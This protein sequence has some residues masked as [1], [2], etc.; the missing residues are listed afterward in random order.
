MQRTVEPAVAVRSGVGA[1]GQRAGRAVGAGVAVV[2]LLL[3][4]GGRGHGPAMALG[5]RGKGIC[6]GAP[7]GPR[8]VVARRAGR[9]HG[10]QV[11]GQILGRGVLVDA[12]R[13][14][15]MLGVL[16]LEVAPGV[17]LILG[18]SEE[19]MYALG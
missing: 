13:L 8:P 16:L 4:V 6:A 7:G 14:H 5:P 1:G 17:S 10:S 18:C 12:S 9:A 2:V 11:V 3:L 19:N 15:H